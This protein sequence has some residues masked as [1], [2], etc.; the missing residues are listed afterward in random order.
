MCS[1]DL[2]EYG[3][4]NGEGFILITGEIGSGKTTLVRKLLRSNIHPNAKIAYVVNPRGT[5][6]QLMRVIMAE[7]GVIP[8][9]E[10]AP[11]ERLLAEFEKFARD[12]ATKGLP[13]I[14]IIDEAQ[15]VDPQTL[16]ELRMLSNLETEKQKLVQI[17]LVGQPELRQTLAAPEFEQLS[18]RIAVRY[19]IE[20]LSLQETER[21]IHHRLEVAG[22]KDSPVKFTH[23]A[24]RIIH[25]WSRGVPRKINVAC[26]AV[27]VWG[28]ADNR[29]QFDGRYVREVILGLDASA[30]LGPEPAEEPAQPA[31]A[32][33]R[34][35]PVKA[36][37]DRRV[38]V[39]TALGTV[40]VIALVLY[41]W[42]GV[43]DIIR[44]AVN[45]LA[46]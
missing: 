1:S 28:M 20:P 30:K 39:G 3:L 44:S 17:V 25:A 9:T 24:C 6:R 7:F 2:L 40:A 12:R 34:P 43:V 15:N 16:E 27:L 36:R 21:Y 38:L 29:K 10:D 11:R 19:H 5:F 37:S 23:D 41:G 46:R 35:V 8:I 4:N 42:S 31:P 18:Q 26:N 14:I 33:P 45:S 32:P 22:G 13:T